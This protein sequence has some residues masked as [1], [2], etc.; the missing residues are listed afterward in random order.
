M[1]HQ[2][3]KKRIQARAALRKRDAKAVGRY[4][5][6]R[7]ILGVNI[8]SYP[9]TWMGV[10][11]RAAT[12]VNITNGGEFRGITVTKKEDGWLV[13]LKTSYKGKKYV[14]F[15]RGDSFHEALLVAGGLLAAKEIRWEMDKY[16][17]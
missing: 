6:T 14:G 2:K 12:N 5:L 17:Q 7:A 9:Y 4:G 13:T 10:L 11:L 16:S 1:Q 8:K 15:S 3:L